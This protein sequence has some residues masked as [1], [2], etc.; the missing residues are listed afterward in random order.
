[1]SP[2]ANYSSIISS[3]TEKV[4]L[5]FFGLVIFTIPIG[6]IIHQVTIS[7]ASP[8]ARKRLYIERSVSSRFSKYKVLDG[9]E[10]KNYNSNIVLMKSITDEYEFDQKNSVSTKQMFKK[11]EYVDMEYIR[12]QIANRYSFYYAMIEN[13][14]IAPLCAF[15]FYRLVQ[16]HFG[17]NDNALFGAHTLWSP[18]L[19]PVIALVVCY[20]LIL[21]IPNLLRE[22]NDIENILLDMRTDQL[23]SFYF[24]DEIKIGRSE[25]AQQG[26]R[27][28]AN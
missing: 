16:P 22:V 5:A 17:V 1:M 20:L 7:V 14:L 4:A 3:T 15:A 25:I 26:D 13:V 19:F 10:D 11:K 12:E 18:W 2:H 21:Y 23:K 9:V 6:F 8:F 28:Q 24:R 27:R